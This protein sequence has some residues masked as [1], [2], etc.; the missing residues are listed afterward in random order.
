MKPRVWLGKTGPEAVERLGV[1]QPHR[2][3]RPKGAAALG[4]MALG[5]IA[6]PAGAQAPTAAPAAASPTEPAPY[7]DRVIEGLAPAASSAP[8][9]QPYDG[10]GWPRFLRLESR[11]GTQPFDTEGSTQNSLALYGLID[12]PNHGALS[13]DGAYT[14]SSS[15]GNLTLRQRGLPLEGGWVGNHEGGVINAPA[16]DLSRLPGRVYLPSATLLGASGE[17]RNAGQG[18]SVIAGSGQPGQLQSLPSTGFTGLGGRRHTLGAQWRP[19]GGA[20]DNTPSLKLPG[21]TLAVQHENASDLSGLVQSTDTS[22]TASTSALRTAASATL[23][24]A[25]HESEGQRIQAQVIT[26]ASDVPA[27]STATS[28]ATTTTTSTIARSAQGFW[29]DSQWDEGPRTHG[30]S[31]YR[32]DPGLSWAGQTMPN[33]LQGV[34]VSTAWRTRQWQ[35]EGSIDW[36][37]SISGDRAAGS[38]ASASAR[39]RLD[40]SSN[41]GAGGSVRR[42]DGNA[43]STYGDWRFDNRWGNSGLRLEL[44]GGDSDQTRS[45]VLTYDQDWSAPQGWTVS[46]SVGLG[47][48]R[49]TLEEGL[50]QSDRFWTASTALN[51]PVGSRASLNATASLERS[52]LGRNRQALSLGG[53]WRIN[54]RWTL[55]ANF[56]RSLGRSVT[57][58]TS[59]DPLAPIITTTASQSDSDR[60]FYVVL[61]YEF[62]AGSRSVPLG[63]QAFEGGGFIEGVVYYDANRTGTQEASETGVPNVT[64]FIDNRYGVRTD[65][66]GRFSFPLV[67]T[68]PRTVTLRNETLPLPWNVVNEG[69]ALVEVRLRETTRLSLP[70]Q[71]SE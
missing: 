42:F 59:L 24:A 61:R 66:Q 45:Q 62:E 21:W 5:W 67:G 33:D 10:S 1:V 43:W 71:R 68:G 57:T 23:L 25:R 26:S 12:T 17:W 34:A 55:D 53:N 48:E 27:T 19:G 6:S 15:S 2:R 51:A 60:S 35:A 44:A 52:Q 36:L 13:L 30:L 11:V 4:L 8:S 7:Q 3:L 58:T 9:G 63:G 32:L 46:S 40:R 22:T 69:Q 18:L 49:D 41:V 31:L 29:V 16:T 38:Y 20:P 37:R 56:N 47:V 70:V 64:V 65:A 39:W 50:T 54:P 14:P 28:T